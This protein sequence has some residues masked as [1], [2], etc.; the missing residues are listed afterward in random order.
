MEQHLLAEAKV[1]LWRVVLGS[2]EPVNSDCPSESVNID[3]D[4]VEM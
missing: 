3:L 1:A 2:P 4:L